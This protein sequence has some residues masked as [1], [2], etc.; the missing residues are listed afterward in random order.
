MLNRGM[1]HNYFLNMSE[2]EKQE[3]KEFV[4]KRKKYLKFCAKAH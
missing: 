4:L 1:Q 2:K 3:L